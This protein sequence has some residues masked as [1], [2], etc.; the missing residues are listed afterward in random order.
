M[1]LLIVYTAFFDQH[2]TAHL[3]EVTFEAIFVGAVFW[4]AR[5]W[6]T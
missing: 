1:V 5:R 3:F 6:S 4:A 2:A